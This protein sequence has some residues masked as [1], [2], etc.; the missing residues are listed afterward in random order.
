[1]GGSDVRVRVCGCESAKCVSLT[2][3]TRAKLDFQTPPF[4][5]C[6]VLRFEDHSEV[7]ILVHKVSKFP[8][9]CFHPF[10]PRKV[11]VKT[12]SGVDHVNKVT[13]SSVTS[14]VCCG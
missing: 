4:Y 14:I 9:S 3:A 10:A 7:S 11:A 8:T 1:V 5:F 6:S 13:H 12:L 2:Q